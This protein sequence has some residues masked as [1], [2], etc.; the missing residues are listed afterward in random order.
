MHRRHILDLFD[1]YERRFPKER[2]TVARIRAFV[3]GHRDCFERSLLVGHITGSAWLLGADMARVLLTHHRKLDIW[4][5]L[6]GHA[7]GEADISKV[8]MKEAREESGLARIELLSQEIF[9]ID[10][11][12]IPARGTE[13][14]HFHY[15]CRFLLRAVGVQDYVV[16]DESHDLAWIPLHKVS[17]YTAEASIMRMLDKTGQG[18]FM[19]PVT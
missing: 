16:S 7:D 4:V 15:D 10:I 19:K 13:P 2:E 9:D 8:A 6:G 5:Q 11:H 17:D 12:T 3:E 14:V 1:Q 18:L